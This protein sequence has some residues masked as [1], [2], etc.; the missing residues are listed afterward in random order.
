MHVAAGFDHV[1]ILLKSGR[2]LSLGCAEGGRLGRFAEEEAEVAVRDGP[3]E[4]IRGRLAERL[5]PATVTGLPTDIT[6][7][8]AVRPRASTPTSASH[9]RAQGGFASF[10]VSA[11]GKVYVWGLNNYGQLALPVPP[12]KSAAAGSVAT[13]PGAAL[14]V[15]APRASPLLSGACCPPL[16]AGC[17]SHSASRRGEALLDFGGRAPHAG[18]H[19]LGGVLFWAL[20]VRPAGPRGRGPWQRRAAP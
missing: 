18:A 2:V 8:A 6:F 12:P 10:A 9:P 7:V 20:H 14:M 4:L 1:L 17:V 3:P 19:A 5:T 11:D 15:Y 16:L 13:A